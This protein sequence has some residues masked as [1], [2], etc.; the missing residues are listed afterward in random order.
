MP[1][2]Y[3]FSSRWP[4]GKMVL[5]VIVIWT[6]LVLVSLLTQREQLNRTASALARIDAVANLKK[7][8]SIRKWASDAKGVFVLEQHVPALNS[9]EEEER[10]TA[11]RNNGEILR[12]VTV[13]PIHLL[14]AIQEASNE[15]ATSNRE[16][17]TSKQLRN[18]DN[19]PDD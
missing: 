18:I 4:G 1:S 7:D 17:L 10:L 11:I 9:L 15:G 5:L 8:M 6:V 2:K 14:L 3:N 12:L 16:R 13:T 19:A